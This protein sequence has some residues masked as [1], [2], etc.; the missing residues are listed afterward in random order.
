MLD[1][2]RNIGIIAHIDAGKTTTSERI[3]YYTGKE[4][5]LGNIDEGTC[6]LD[7]MPEEQAHGVTITAAATV[8]FWKD[9]RINLIDTPG[10]VDFT[11]E[12]ERSLRVLDG[13]VGVFCGVGG[14][15]PQSETVW[16]QANRYRVPRI[17]FVNK[18][19]RLGADFQRAL[20]SIKEKLGANP[21]PLAW[22]V[23]RESAFRG[24]VDLVRRKLLTY[25]EAS[26][27]REVLESEVPSEM[28]DEIEIR[29][30]DMVDAVADAVGWMTEKWY[31][32]EE[33]T[34]E[35]LKRGI[36]EATLALKLTP[37][38]CGSSLKNK[39]VQL[40]LDGVID[41]LP[42]PLDVPPMVGTD[43]R[44][45]QPATRKPEEKAPMCALMFKSWTDA[46]GEL[47]YVRVYSGRLDT[48]AAVHNPREDKKERIQ[49]IFLMHANTPQQVDSV[50]P[51]EIAAVRGLRFTKTG[52][53]LCDPR[54]PIVL[55]RMVFPETVIS[56]SIEPKSAE[57]RD[58]L[59]QTLERMAKDDPTFTS[60]MDEETG[61]TI[62]SGMGEFHLEI[63]R[64]KMLREFKVSA[65]VGA[66]RVAYK[67]T[68]KHA[69]TGEGKFIRKI[70]ERGQYGHVVLTVEPNP[71]KTQVVLENRLTPESVPRAFHA[72][73]E[74]SARSS[75]L[76]GGKWGYALIYVKIALIG[77]S[78]HPTDATEAAFSAATALALRDAM[79]KAGSDM[80]EPYMKF[81]TRTP[82]NFLG[83]VLSDLHRRRAE[84]T[85]VDA[86]DELSIVHGTVPIAEMFGYATMLR[87]LTQGRGDFTMEPLDYRAI[88]AEERKRRFGDVE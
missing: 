69:A 38:F 4:H 19:D 82:A 59:I 13:A 74:D 50:G 72:T 84:I 32:K 42:S 80:L 12:V 87:S 17:A 67:E 55:E 22:P 46:Y 1:K 27:G 39:G 58:K 25:D 37:V 68:I 49:R 16:R 61:Q 62:V 11:A 78:S 24:I 18:L 85:Q 15:E 65:N 52:D 34:E 64:E 5:K 75:A 29:R 21:V 77:G 63:L 7:W 57:D 48:S 88:P 36:R 53:T 31:A 79:E 2:F 66:P 60:R 23:G 20:K 70:A 26:L 76:G 56:M 10:H 44:T 3:L 8:C 86:Q 28:V 6:A 41:Y 14:V 73:V 71:S 54:H 51:G 35:E 83:E 30:S 45:G 33:F 81:D 43:P 9:Y 40:L 47:D